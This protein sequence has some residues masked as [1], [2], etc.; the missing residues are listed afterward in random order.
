M[1]TGLLKSYVG[2]G[3]VAER[4]ADPVILDDMVG[5]WYDDVTHFLYG[6]VNGDG[7]RRIFSP[8]PV[9]T[10]A[11]GTDTADADEPGT[12]IIY[13]SANATVTFDG[14]AYPQDGEYYI[15]AATGAEV[16]LDVA[17][18]FTLDAPLGG[19]LVI[20]AGGVG[21]VKITA[22]D[23]GKLTAFVPPTPVAPDPPAVV[24]E[25]TTARTATPGNAGE[26]TRF[27]HADAKT[28]TF[29]DAETYVQGAEYFGRNVGA[30]DLT[31]T[32]V[33]AITPNA[34]AGGTLVVPQGGSFSVKMA[35]ATEGDVIGY[36]EAA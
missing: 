21:M 30:G 33:G 25:A 15:E 36:T 3:P 18:G 22:P 35:S 13:T 20:P 7:W 26:Y 23:R 29:T 12:Y 16:T 4:P 24:T 1:A 17:N 34:P 11:A 6:Y 10:V 19:S 27:T 28:Y 32:A 9:S 31:L 2:A 14:V 5:L 8:A